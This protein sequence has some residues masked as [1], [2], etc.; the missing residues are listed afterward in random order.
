MDLQILGA[1]SD[2]AWFERPYSTWRW[3]CK[4]FFNL[5][6]EDALAGCP[7][8]R[9]GSRGYPATVRGSVPEHEGM[10]LVSSFLD[11]KPKALHRRLRPCR[12]LLSCTL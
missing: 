6:T 2:V 7:G 3:M 4:T 10:V 5:D 11:N 9:G 1:K 8:P 12:D